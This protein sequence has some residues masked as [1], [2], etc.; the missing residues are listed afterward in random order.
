MG[1]Y[2]YLKGII[3]HFNGTTPSVAEATHCYDASHTLT[4]SSLIVDLDFR[5]RGLVSEV[6]GFYNPELASRIINASLNERNLLVYNE[7]VSGNIS[8]EQA[9][10]LVDNGIVTSSCIPISEYSVSYKPFSHIAPW[11]FDGDETYRNEKFIEPIFLTQ[12]LENALE[13][14]ESGERLD[15]LNEGFTDHIAPYTPVDREEGY[16]RSR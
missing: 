7:I 10:E 9:R 2:S 8:V 16:K 11:R 15:Y 5:K 13:K 12:E 3:S 14:L 4:V 1:K 6:I